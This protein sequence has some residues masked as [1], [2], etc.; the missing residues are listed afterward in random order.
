[1]TRRSQSCSLEGLSKNS[2]TFVGFYEKGPLQARVS[3]TWRDHYLVA[4]QTQTGVP[5]FNDSYKQPW[6]GYRERWSL[7]S[8][9]D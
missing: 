2:A 8:R 7:R 5:Q 4:P 9:A 1:M 3:Y 6:V